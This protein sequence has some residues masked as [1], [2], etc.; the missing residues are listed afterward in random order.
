MKRGRS[1]LE[2]CE[3]HG[4]GS[5]SEL[6]VVEGNSAAMAVLHV[7]DPRTQAVL[8]MQGKPM[9]ALRAT[10]GRV[11]ANPFLSALGDAI[12]TGRGAAFDLSALRYERIVLLMDP[13]ADGIHAGALLL[14]F[15]HRFMPA[16]VERG[17]L[18]RVHAPLG[19]LRPEPGGAPVYAYT[20]SQFQALAAQ[21][22]TAGGPMVTAL[23]YRG[24]AG[25]DAEVLA[26]QCVRR[27][28]RHGRVLAPDDARSAMEVFASLRELPRQGSLF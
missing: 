1:R 22:R 8:P 10:D 4:P 18:E 23:R 21:L 5:E 20:E 24:L 2:D 6:F 17:Q 7:R 14:T 28:T 11:A 26:G 27:A 13:D 3:R 19:E 25:L 16:I 12:G 15:L 9:N